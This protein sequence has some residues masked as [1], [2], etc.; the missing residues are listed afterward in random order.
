MDTE[1]DDQVEQLGLLTT[2]RLDIKHLFLPPKITPDRDFEVMAPIEP[3]PDGS[4]SQPQSGGEETRQ[5]PRSTPPPTFWTWTWPPWAGRAG[6]RTCSGWRTTLPAPPH[7]KERVHGMFAG[8]NVI[9]IVLEASPA[10]P[11]T[12]S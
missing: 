9:Q 11:S 3:E 10:M 2:L 8:Y 7:E 6:T 5:S 12:R 4:S 1:T